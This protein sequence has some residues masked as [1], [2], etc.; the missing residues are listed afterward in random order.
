MASWHNTIWHTSDSRIIKVLQGLCSGVCG[1]SLRNLLA[2]S[3]NTD[4]GIE[5]S[6]ETG[7]E[8]DGQATMPYGRGKASTRT[9]AQ[10]Q[11]PEPS[12]GRP[13]TLVGSLRVN[14]GP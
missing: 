2:Q 9:L 14:P 5:Q 6:P 8:S 4:V 13:K 1:T 11:K 3:A 10:P 7:T 12:P